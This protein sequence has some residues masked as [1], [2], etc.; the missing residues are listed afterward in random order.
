MA[1][2]HDHVLAGDQVLVVE[3]EPQSWITVRRGVAKAAF[4]SESSVLMISWMR[5]RERRMSR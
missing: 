2:G 3:I 1:D 5:A 4:T